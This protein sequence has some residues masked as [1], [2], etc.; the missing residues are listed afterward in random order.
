V[1]T[2]HSTTASGDDAAFHARG[3]DRNTTRVDGAVLCLHLRANARIEQ[4][5]SRSFRF[6][7]ARLDSWSLNLRLSNSRSPDKD[8][9]EPYQEKKNE[10]RLGLH[11]APSGTGLRCKHSGTQQG[12]S[13]S[14]EAQGS[15]WERQ[16]RQHR[17]PMMPS[18]RVR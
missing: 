15:A 10:K 6:S 17:S 12:P 16:G 11:C 5:G 1:S 9:E 14:A 2:C 4:G 8:Y 3:R 18:G 7:L 13:V